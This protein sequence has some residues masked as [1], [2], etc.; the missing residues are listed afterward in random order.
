MSL[1][2]L[3]WNP[4]NDEYGNVKASI[5]IKPTL[6]LLEFANRNTSN[7]NRTMMVQINGTDHPVYEGSV[8]L[9]ILDKT[10]DVPECRQNFFNATGLYLMTLSLTWN[11]YPNTNGAVTFYEGVLSESASS[12]SQ[13]QSPTPSPSVS[14]SPSPQVVEKYETTNSGAKPVDNKDDKDYTHKKPKCGT[15]GFSGLTLFLVGLSFFILLFAIVYVSGL[16]R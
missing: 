5:Y 13:S 14:P 11:G 10:S 4:I 1:P 3:Q 6:S 8:P 7:G 2:I 12:Q 15:D 9:A 16:K